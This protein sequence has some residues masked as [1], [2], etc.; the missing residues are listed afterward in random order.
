MDLKNRHEHMRGKTVLVNGNR[1]QV[2]QDGVARNV[3]QADAKKLLQGEAWR[4]HTARKA[5]SKPDTKPSI[6]VPAAK[7][8]PAPAPEAP[9]PPV[10]PEPE[11][12]E[13]P[14]AVEDDGASWPDP[15]ESMDLE[16]LQQMADAYEVEY[17][18]RTAKK[19]LVKRIMAAM[20]PE[21]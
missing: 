13:A 10:E 11:A 2:E 6:P 7:P 16:F 20:Y 15:D 18:A 8:E 3:D 4:I 1:Y 17:T 21:E 14:E 19:T 5:V 9:T 12:Q